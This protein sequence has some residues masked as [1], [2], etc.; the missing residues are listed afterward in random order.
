MSPAMPDLDLE[1]AMQTD[2][3]HYS[4]TDHIARVRFARPATLGSLTFNV[5]RDLTDLMYRLR[6]D[7]SVKVVVIEGEGKGFCSGGD[8]N[9]IIGELL[10]RD[11]KGLLEF[12]RMTGEL[13]VN[14]RQLEKPIV[15][16]INGVAA[17]AGS[18]LV[19]ACCAGVVCAGVCTA[20]FCGSRAGATATCGA[21]RPAG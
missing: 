7:E 5:Y 17:G 18:V 16:A 21:G 1:A 14:M 2:S 10:K 19:G 12:T 9:E 20:G 8:V 3:F 11:T 15:S 4:V 6:F 13:I